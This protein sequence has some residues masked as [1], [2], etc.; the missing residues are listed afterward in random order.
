MWVIFIFN[1]EYRE[2]G[3]LNHWDEVLFSYDP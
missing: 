1:P 2:K 3:F